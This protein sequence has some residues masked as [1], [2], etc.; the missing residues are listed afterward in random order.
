MCKPMYL[1]KC[2]CASLCLS[3]VANTHQTIWLP[4]D[5]GLKEPLLTSTM[6][7]CTI[8]VF[9][10]FFLS[11][12]LFP[13]NVIW[14]SPTSQWLLSLHQIK[15][16]DSTAWSSKIP[17]V[18]ISTWTCDKGCKPSMFG[19]CT[20]KGSHHLS[21]LPQRGPHIPC[22]LR[23][24]SWSN[25]R[26]PCSALLLLVA[27]Q[28]SAFHPHYLPTSSSHCPSLAPGARLS[29]SREGASSFKPIF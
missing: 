14:V 23:L 6:E 2:K 4:P 19:S 3:V 11:S 5:G 10:I 21:S 12:G 28:T 7:S 22:L 20:N 13:E 8:F 18:G 17:F 29:I 27:A 1:C 16:Q 25:L 26:C 15:L 9:S 24:Q